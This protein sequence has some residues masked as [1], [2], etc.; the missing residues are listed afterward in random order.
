MT[1][2]VE[3]GTEGSDDLPEAEAMKLKPLS[4]AEF[5][6]EHPDDR[7]DDEEVIAR[8]MEAGRG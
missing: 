6:A 3:Q 8:A 7:P 2:E 1:H 5:L 4:Y